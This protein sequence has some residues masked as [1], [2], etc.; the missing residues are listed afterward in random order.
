VCSVIASPAELIAL[1]IGLL[2]RL[3]RSEHLIATNEPVPQQAP[4]LFVGR[5]ETGVVVRC[6]H[7]LDPALAEKIS[8][9]A[10]ELPRY[11]E[12]RG[13]GDVYA[14]I[15]AAVGTAA[16]I[17]SRWHGLACRFSEPS[18]GADPRVVAIAEDASALVGP[19]ARFRSF[20]DEVA[21]FFAIVHDGAVVSGCYSARQSHAGAEAGVDT[22]PAFRGQ[23][24]AVAV[25]D[26]WRLAIER[27]GRTPLYS[28]S[29][30][31][32]SSRAL[33]RRLGLVQYAET[34]ALS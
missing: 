13:D 14:P 7:D 11:P 1:H 6:R 9:W 23:R 32:A 30:D 21:P 2:Y 19:F 17:A 10:R 5:T 20:L 12:A 25:V 8:R 28:T 18:R 16:P 29:Y 33:A 4:R 15:V 26:A 22:V 27:T 34:F 24:Y 31:N 3:D